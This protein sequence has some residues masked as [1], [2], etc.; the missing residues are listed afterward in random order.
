VLVAGHVVKQLQAG[1]IGTCGTARTHR[2]PLHALLSLLN[3]RVRVGKPLARDSSIFNI[4]I[5]NNNVYINVLHIF[6]IIFLLAAA[7]QDTLKIFFCSYVSMF[8][9]HK[10]IIHLVRPVTN[11]TAYPIYGKSFVHRVRK[12]VTP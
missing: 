6:L 1:H 2:F 12:K 3:P 4:K 10:L 9:G 11:F 7:L 8:I 5:V